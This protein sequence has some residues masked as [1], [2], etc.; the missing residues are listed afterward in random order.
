MKMTEIC[1]LRIDGKGTLSYM[2]RFHKRII[3]SAALALAI[4]L[5]VAALILPP[6]ASGGIQAASV[7]TAAPCKY[8]IGDYC[9]Y[10]AVYVSGQSV[11][12][13]IT[14]TKIATLPFADRQMLTAGIAIYTE[15]ELSIILEDYGT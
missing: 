11:P 3:L 10:V 5:S 14:E 1:L 12:A 8:I 13:Y 15:E 7:T 4:I 9:G 2:T 6:T